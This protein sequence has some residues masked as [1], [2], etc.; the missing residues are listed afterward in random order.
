MPPGSSWGI[1]VLTAM[2][3]LPNLPLLFCLQLPGGC[4]QLGSQ[5]ACLSDI[6]FLVRSVTL[7]GPP[8]PVF[9]GHSHFLG[10]KL[11]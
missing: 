6:I 7:L 2:K 8:L 3:H 5:T 1:T 10:A 4:A 9:L 11:K